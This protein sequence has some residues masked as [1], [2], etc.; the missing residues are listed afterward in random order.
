MACPESRSQCVWSSNVTLC[1]LRSRD[2]V[3]VSGFSSNENPQQTLGALSPPQHI[4]FRAPRKHCCSEAGPPVG[5]L[6]LVLFNLVAYSRGSFSIGQACLC[7]IENQGPSGTGASRAHT[8]EDLAE[9]DCSECCG[10]VQDVP[11]PASPC[12]EMLGCR[13]FLQGRHFLVRWACGWPRGNLTLP[14]N[15]SKHTKEH[16]AV[17]P[18]LRDPVHSS[19][20]RSG[21]AVFA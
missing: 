8:Q 19:P 14:K 1:S 3:T 10:H 17:R 16:P 21:Q 18:D 12:P 13:A 7:V 15:K 20:S 9:N 5:R 6:G 2:P 4:T 11:L